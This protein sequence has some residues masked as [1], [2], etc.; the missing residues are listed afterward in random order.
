[1]TCAQFLRQLNLATTLAVALVLPLPVGAQQP[2]PSVRLPSIT[3]VQPPDGG[4]IPAD[5]PVLAFRFTAADPS[6]QLDLGSLKVAVDSHDATPSFHVTPNDAWGKLDG[7][8]VPGGSLAVGAHTVTAR[9][10]SL[11][12]VCGIMTASFNVSAPALPIEAAPNASKNSNGPRGLVGTLVKA[13]RK[14]IGP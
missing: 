7:S 1:M 5:R 8:A 2:P 13:A 6:D 12:G 14:I 10:C 4:T 11:R 9:I 3:L